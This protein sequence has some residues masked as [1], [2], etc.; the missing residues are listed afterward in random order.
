MGKE[1]RLVRIGHMEK[2][3]FLGGETME[4]TFLERNLVNEK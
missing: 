2:G 1:R 4:G 3:D